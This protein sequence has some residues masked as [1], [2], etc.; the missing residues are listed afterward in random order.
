MTFDPS[1]D[2]GS[3][4]GSCNGGG[5]GASGVNS[6]EG[7]GEGGLGG[8][9]EAGTRRDKQALPSRHH[10][11]VIVLCPITQF[12]QACVY[13]K[14]ASRRIS[15]EDEQKEAAASSDERA[16]AA[17]GSG[18][19]SMDSFA[20]SGYARSASFSA[21]KAVPRGGNGSEDTCAL[22]AAGVCLLCDIG[23]ICQLLFPGLCLT[24]SLSHPA[25]V[26]GRGSGDPGD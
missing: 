10:P 9:D 12:E 14:V 19:S 25:F 2:G 24:C 20:V 22:A 3:G 26:C 16:P 18:M 1:G 23:F 7:A 13:R 5:G 6:S 11:H 17:A 21:S 4:D 8:D 15:D